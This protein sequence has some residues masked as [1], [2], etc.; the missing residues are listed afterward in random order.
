MIRGFFLWSVS[1]DEFVC[2]A[3][4]SCRLV[5]S[6]VGWLVTV[7]SAWRLVSGRPIFSVAGGWTAGGSG[8]TGGGWVFKCLVLRV[9]G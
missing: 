7:G 8:D 1:E 3:R 9:I 4:F 6:S 2:R 5:V